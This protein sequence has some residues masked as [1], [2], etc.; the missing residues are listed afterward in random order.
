MTGRASKLVMRIRAKLTLPVSTSKT[1]PITDTTPTHTQ[2]TNTQKTTRRTH[3][4]KHSH[5]HAC[6]PTNKHRE[7]AQHGHKRNAHTGTTHAR[8]HTNAQHT[9]TPGCR[10]DTCAHVGTKNTCVETHTYARSPMHIRSATID[11]HTH[12][13]ACTRTFAHER[14]RADKCS[15]VL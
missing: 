13:H 6:A 14:I 10:I 5:T 8:A 7:L 9:H 12:R 3:K 4:R 2:L 15:V 1:F 11:V